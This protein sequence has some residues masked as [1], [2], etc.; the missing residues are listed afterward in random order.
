MKIAISC[1]GNNVSGHF[2]RCEKYV[3]FDEENGKLIGKKELDSPQH[4]PGL[5]PK[6]LNEQGAKKIICQ[7]IGPK[8]IDLFGE[9]GIEVIAGISGEI[10]EV[11]ESYI[12]GDLAGSDSTCDHER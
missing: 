2:G 1:D 3:L 5:I 10:N 12:K 8:A 9:L 7:G 11:I 4:A 6:F